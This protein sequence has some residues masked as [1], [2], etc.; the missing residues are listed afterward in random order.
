M[1]FIF[2]AW[3]AAAW[4]SEVGDGL[5]ERRLLD[6]PVLLFR[7]EDGKIAAIG[8]RC[9]HRFAPLSAGR[10]MGSVVKCG[11]YGLKFDRRGACVGGLSGYNQPDVRVPAYPAVERHEMIWIW[12]GE[13]SEA[14]PRLIPDLGIMSSGSGEPAT[15]YIRH[16]CDYR[17]A[18]DNLMDLSHSAVLHVDTLGRVTP[19]LAEGKLS[20]TRE[21]DCV[22]AS[23]KM[24]DVRLAPDGEPVDQWLD[25]RWLPVGVMLI[26]AMAVPVGGEKPPF[27]GRVVH[28]LTP[29]TAKSTHYFTG[30][31][32][33]LVGLDFDRDP[34]LDEDVPMLA[35]CQEMMGDE[36]FW[37]LDPLILPSDAA[38]IGVRRVIEQLVKRQEAA[39]ASVAA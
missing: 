4:S 6:K 22:H 15:R 7:D 27:V 18:T 25:M 14:D 16:R 37:D 30:S 1:T 33:P 29:E 5:F 11:Y 21:G 32:E 12:M 24:S 10:K 19:G 31:P 26:D 39:R 35:A 2:N 23:T 9:P 13:A 38:A 20:V 3:Y 8:N 34:F 28:V 17:L 36:E